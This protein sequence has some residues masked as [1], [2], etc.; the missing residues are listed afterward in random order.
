ME[1]CPMKKAKLVKQLYYFHGNFEQVT[2]MYPCS[3]NK[4]LEQGYIIAYLSSNPNSIQKVT[5][6]KHLQYSSFPSWHLWVDA[7]ANL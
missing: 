2:S 6:K 4:V 3:R 7:S 5:Q 1:K